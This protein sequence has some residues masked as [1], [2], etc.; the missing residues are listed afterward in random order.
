MPPVDGPPAGRGGAARR[1]DTTST[2][3]L[4]ASY[5]P[6]RRNCAFGEPGL[7]GIGWTCGGS[8][9]AYIS[10]APENRLC[11]A[12]GGDDGAAGVPVPA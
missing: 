6:V 1:F 11:A 10:T 4:L 7:L 12:C 2:T 3:S 5:A 9:A 8:K